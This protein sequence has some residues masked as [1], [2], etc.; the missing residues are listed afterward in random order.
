M[1]FNT[2]WLTSQKGYSD[3]SLK[4]IF[5]I[6]WRSFF[7]YMMCHEKVSDRF[8]TLH[9]WKVAY[10]LHWLSCKLQYRK[11]ANHSDTDFLH[12][13]VLNAYVVFS[14][15]G[16]DITFEP[17]IGPCHCITCSVVLTSYEEQLL[18][19]LCFLNNINIILWHTQ[20]KILLQLW[21]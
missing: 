21:D 3:F 14:T 6:G 19:I 15:P 17:H 11:K 4:Q 2:T 1:C 16:C 12:K 20:L 8:K 5:L 9:P 7:L 10:L 18:L 13:F